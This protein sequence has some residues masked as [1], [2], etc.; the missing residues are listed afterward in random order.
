MLKNIRLH[1]EKDEQKQAELD[2]K[3]AVHIITTHN[4]NLILY[5]NNLNCYPKK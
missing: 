3:L 4:S 1:I 2:E 5:K